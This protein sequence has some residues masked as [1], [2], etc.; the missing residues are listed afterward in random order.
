MYITIQKFRGSSEKKYRCLPVH[1]MQFRKSGQTSKDRF[2]L[3]F[4]QFPIF[5]FAHSLEN[6]YILAPA[7]CRRRSG[8]ETFWRWDFIRLNVFASRSYGTIVVATKQKMF[9]VMS[10]YI[11]CHCV[12]FSNCTLLLF[13]ENTQHFASIYFSHRR[14]RA[15]KAG[16]EHKTDLYKCLRIFCECTAY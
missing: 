12:Y 10:K 14:V 15:P 11:R 2:F 4:S 5:F 7:F 6:L 13:F 1:S 9:K 8:A 16:L 3:S